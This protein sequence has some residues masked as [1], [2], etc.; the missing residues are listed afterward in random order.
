MTPEGILTVTA[1]S[2]V[3]R[4]SRPPGLHH[5][6]PRVLTRPPHRPG[7]PPPTTDPADDP[8]F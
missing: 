7:E 3:T 1:P 6:G 2:G 4:T 5:T 8:P